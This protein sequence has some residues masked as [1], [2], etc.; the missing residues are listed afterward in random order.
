MTGVSVPAL[1]FS[2]IEEHLGKV[3][4]L[5]HDTPEEAIKLLTSEEFT[6]HSASSAVH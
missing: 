2:G 5:L 6:Q 1:Y 4:P 3:Y